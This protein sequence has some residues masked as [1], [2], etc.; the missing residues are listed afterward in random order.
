MNDRDIDILEHIVRYCGEIGEAKDRFGD[1][2]ETL[3]S[4]SLYRNA[5]AMCILQIGELSTHLSD[6]FKAA[7]SEM[8]WQ[9][10]KGMRNIAA[11]HY[12][13]FDVIKLW[14]TITEDIPHLRAYC[15][16]ILK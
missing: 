5:V 12:S 13:K 7:H 10:M 16:N 3:Q 11:H 4:D 1:S 14:E 2:L 9:D 8:P 15:E 6:D